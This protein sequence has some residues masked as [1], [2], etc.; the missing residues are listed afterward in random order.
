MKNFAIEK[1]IIISLAAL[2]FISSTAFAA[3]TVYNPASA[4]VQV[5]LLKYLPYPAEPGGYTTLT[6]EVENR[7]NADADNVRLKLSPDYPFSLDPNSTVTILNSANSTPVSSDDTVSLGRLPY[8]QYTI[9]EYKIRVAPDALEGY[10][11]IKVW[12]QTHADD[13]WLINEFNVFVHGTD[14]LELSISP[15]ILSPGKPTAA[16]F[17]INNT[18]TAYIHNLALTWSEANN[19]VLPLG[20]GSWPR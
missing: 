13:S 7:G 19:K 17:V 3:Q 11:P 16:T 4:D 10:T 8:W 14:Q 6:L 1:S 5:S 2:L 18:G 20:S 12:S 9:V 15:S